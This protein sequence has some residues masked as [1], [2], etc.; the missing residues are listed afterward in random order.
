MT[1][2]YASKT[3]AEQELWAFGDKHPELDITTC[4]SGGHTICVLQ[5]LTPHAVN[6]PFLYGPF[7]DSFNAPPTPNYS[8]L[9]TNLY[10]HRLLNPTGVFPRSPGHAD[11]R[12][13][14]KAH[15]LALTSPPTS[16]VE[17]KRILFASPH[18]FDYGAV[19]ALIAEKRPDLKSRLIGATP[20]ALA[21]NRIP[22]DFSRIHQVLG[23]D[24]SEFKEIQDT[25]LSAVASLLVL[26]QAWVAAGAE[27][28]IPN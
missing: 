9:S 22:I 15:V 16:A 17:R 3:L 20:P 2:Y 28:S 21:Y 12:D 7:A 26:E 11:V 5:S 24:K 8:A 27:I 25:M 14:A 10:I 19:V 6:P 23:M 18:G 4:K 1:A 13:A